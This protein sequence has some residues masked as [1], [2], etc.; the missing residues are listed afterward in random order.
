MIYGIGTDI[1]RV[2]RMADNIAR[3]GERFAR[4]LLA[5]EELVDYANA[6]DPARFL[7]KRF[8]AKEAVVKAIGTGF[9]DGISL[10][11]IAVRH[12]VLGKPLLYC[13]DRLA[14]VMLARGVGEGH[15]S[16]S[17]EQDYA[18]AFVVYLHKRDG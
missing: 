18:L 11:H 8:A 9:R 3:H 15:L 12:D 2:A 4:K 10:R 17:D 5:E 14:E 13:S 1:V 6:P 7:A 16:L